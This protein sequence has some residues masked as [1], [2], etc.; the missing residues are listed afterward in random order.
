[1]LK[2]CREAL[3]RGDSTMIRETRIQGLEDASGSSDP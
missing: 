3:R 2:K 1:M